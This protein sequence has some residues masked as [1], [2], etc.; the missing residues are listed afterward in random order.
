MF[1][2]YVS[3]LQRY[4]IHTV[5]TENKDASYVSLPFFMHY[6]VELMKKMIILSKIPPH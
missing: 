6:Q 2:K 5:S 3:I 1:L 4:C